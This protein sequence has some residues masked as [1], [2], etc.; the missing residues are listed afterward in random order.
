MYT[1]YHEVILWGIKL[2][3]MKV[4]LSNLNSNFIYTPI[5]QKDKTPNKYYYLYFKCKIIYI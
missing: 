4:T 5:L 2:I 3:T 1:N